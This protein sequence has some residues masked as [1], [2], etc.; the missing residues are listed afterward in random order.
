MI[1]GDESC[2]ISA[3]WPQVTEMVCVFGEAFCRTVTEGSLVQPS[4]T[5]KERRNDSLSALGCYRQAAIT[6][7][8]LRINPASGK[9]G[10]P[11]CDH[12]SAGS[13]LC[14]TWWR[15]PPRGKSGAAIPDLFRTDEPEGR[16]LGKPLGVVKADF[17]EGVAASLEK[18]KAEWGK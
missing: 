1:T 11:A 18:R 10:G 15:R 2:A 3:I 8:F 13:A 6:S 5:G 12:K 17:R 14:C 9:S 16:I 7:S 4:G